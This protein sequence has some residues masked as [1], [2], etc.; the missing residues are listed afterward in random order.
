MVADFIKGFPGWF[1]MMPTWEGV[2]GH[3]CGWNVFRVTDSSETRC[4]CGIK[5]PEEIVCGVL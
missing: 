2:V 5:I 3:R 1:S 4:G